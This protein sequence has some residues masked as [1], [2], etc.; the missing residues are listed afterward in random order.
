MHIILFYFQKNYEK[1]SDLWPET[2]FLCGLT[3]VMLRNFS[4][5][6]QKI[7]KWWQF[8]IATSI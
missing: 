4:D 6:N 3:N 5:L 2:P 1:N 7:G 8:L